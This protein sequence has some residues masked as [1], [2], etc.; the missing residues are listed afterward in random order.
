MLWVT[1][2]ARLRGI[3]TRLLDSAAKHYAALGVRQIRLAAAPA[4]EVEHHIAE[5]AGFRAAAVTYVRGLHAG[6]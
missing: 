4:R 1:P 3:A 2:E 6:G 5:K